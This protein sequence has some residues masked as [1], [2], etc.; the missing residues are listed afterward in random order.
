[1]E[2][3]REA[4]LVA[5]ER[6]RR[7]AQ[8]PV[9]SSPHDLEVLLETPPD[10]LYPWIPRAGLVLDDDRRVGDRLT[11]TFRFS[12]PVESGYVA[13]DVVTGERW[14][15][16]S[17]GESKHAIVFLHSVLAEDFGV[18]KKLARNAL[19]AGAH[20]FVQALPFHMARQPEAS[21]YSGQYLL[22]AD[23]VRSVRC[24]AQA[25]TEAASL[26]S[27]LRHRGYERV[28]LA[29]IS[30]GGHI[31]CLAL[32]IEKVEG[33]FLLMPGVD[34]ITTPW[35]TVVGADARRLVDQRGEGTLERALM[36]VNPFHLPAPQ[37]QNDDILFVFGDYDAMCPP[38]RTEALRTAWKGARAHRFPCGHITMSENYPE[39]ANMLALFATAP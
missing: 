36:G 16:A 27:E 12:S 29:G 7:L 20:V 38:E 32:T 19:A 24:Y 4:D 18:E 2:R 11:A 15:H 37:V 33:A 23:V 10:Q 3:H 30:L 34:P 5:L 6:I 9:D 35:Y 21:A 25:A 13:N 26:V 22:S 28:T 39:I 14:R 8:A 1:M 17:H 31:A